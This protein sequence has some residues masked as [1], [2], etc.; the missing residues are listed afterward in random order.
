MRSTVN[1]CGNTVNPPV[2][3]EKLVRLTTGFS[4]NARP[5]GN[6]VMLSRPPVRLTVTGVWS[7]TVR[8]AGN[9]AKDDV[10]RLKVAPNGPGIVPGPP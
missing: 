5:P 3:T 4:G 9:K 2:P 1:P 10:D 7:G 8:P 6:S